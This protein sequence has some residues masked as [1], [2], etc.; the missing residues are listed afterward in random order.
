M[1]LDVANSVVTL[2]STGWTAGNTGGVTPQIGVVYDFKLPKL[3]TSAINNGDYV[4]TYTLPYSQV[5]SGVN[6]TNL[7]T[8][9]PCIIDIR[10]A[11]SRAHGI[12]IRDEVRRILGVNY[13]TPFA[14]DTSF[15]QIEIESID[16]KSDKVLNKNNQ[17]KHRKIIIIRR[18][19][20]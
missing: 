9:E 4:L 16:D 2:L 6:A 19:K 1:A 8:E 13:V 15:T 14:A 5:S 3:A 7:N 20:T 10:T 18:K 11:V 17:I 12:L